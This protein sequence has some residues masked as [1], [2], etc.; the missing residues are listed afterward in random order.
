[1]S[2][3]RT[4]ARSTWAGRLLLIPWRFRSAMTVVLKPVARAIAWTF[5]SREH[6]NYSYD[7]DPRNVDYLAS[8]ISVVTSEPFSK[9]RD[10]IREIENDQS[11]KDRVVR[12]NAAASEK[13]VAD[14]EA[15]FGRRMGWYA[16]VRAAKPRLVVET[17]RKSV[18]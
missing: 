3:I 11:L 7:L 18:V 8:F 15:R 5:R 12:A 2:R 13:Y 9:I 10:Y 1:M 14:R 4:F 6:Y 17:D 16:L